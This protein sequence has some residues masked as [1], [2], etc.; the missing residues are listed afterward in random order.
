M[1]PSINLG[2]AFRSIQKNKVQSVVSILGLGIGLGSIILISMLYMH[3]NSFDKFIPEYDRV[4]RVLHGSNS[5]LPFPMGESAKNDIP[6][7][8]DFFRYHQSRGFDIRQ[9]GK[10]I[11]K[12]THFC[13]CRSFDF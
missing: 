7:I 10:D 13:L 2:I 8:D 5:S 3:E 4:Y 12:E 9:D 11:V 1:N 6:A